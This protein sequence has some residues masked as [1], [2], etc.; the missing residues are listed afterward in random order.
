MVVYFLAAADPR[1]TIHHS[2]AAEKARKINVTS[3]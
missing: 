3:E 2:G 1:M